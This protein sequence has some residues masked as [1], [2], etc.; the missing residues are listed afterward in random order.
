MFVYVRGRLNKQT[1]RGQAVVLWGHPP[2]PH[3]KYSSA[4]GFRQVY[5][6]PFSK[7]D[8]LNSVQ[9]LT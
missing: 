9:I 7:V 1:V 2:D 5:A 8:G 4:K 6:Q 3:Q